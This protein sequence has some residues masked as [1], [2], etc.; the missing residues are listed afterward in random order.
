MKACRRHA[1]SPIFVI[2]SGAG[3][4]ISRACL[5]SR[6][7]ARLLL[8]FLGILDA[9]VH[10]AQE[11]LHEA[12]LDVGELGEVRVHSSSWWSSR[13]LRTMSSTI[14]SRRPGVGLVTVRLALSTAS[15]REMIG[16]F[17]ELGARAR[18]SGSHLRS[19]RARRPRAPCPVSTSRS[20]SFFWSSARR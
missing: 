5:R 10:H 18:D 20:A 19:P 17:L 13:R 6:F 4:S 9:V 12:V 14:C 1:A 7:V 3:S 15:A 8:V 16:A 2:F 11:G